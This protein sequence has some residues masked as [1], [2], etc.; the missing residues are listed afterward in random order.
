MGK[1]RYKGELTL[2]IWGPEWI[3][4]TSLGF[5]NWNIPRKFYLGVFWWGGG[6]DR[7]LITAAR[8]C[9]LLKLVPVVYFTLRLFHPILKIIMI[10]HPFFPV[11]DYMLIT[12]VEKSDWARP[13]YFL[14]WSVQWLCEFWMSVLLSETDIEFIQTSEL[15]RLLRIFSTA[16]VFTSNLL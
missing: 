2:T 15:P 4:C 1:L 9:F 12:A 6:A 8:L 5:L 7:Y 10:K 3:L 14:L 11:N 13:W 16:D